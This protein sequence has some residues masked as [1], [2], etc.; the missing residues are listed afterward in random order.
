M[1]KTSANAECYKAGAKAYGDGTGEAINP[2]PAE[3]RAART[4]DDGYLDRQKLSTNRDGDLSR[5]R[6]TLRLPRVL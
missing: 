3:S 6:A 1:K 5:K 4:W 2:H